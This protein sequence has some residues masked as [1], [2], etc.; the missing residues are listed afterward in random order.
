MAYA[1][2]VR[3][4]IIAAA[5]WMEA[6]Q[7]R[8]GEISTGLGS[9]DLDNTFMGCTW[10]PKDCYKPDPPMS[11]ASDVD[12]YNLAVIE[13]NAYLREVKSFEDCVIAEAKRDA[14]E[15]LP[16]LISQ[17]AKKA[18]DDADSEAREARESLDMM[19]PH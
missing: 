14:D 2:T 12:S 19:Q 9:C 13:F 4:A 10:K 5:L 18:L 3:S 16:D 8:A 17:S 1:L 7:A 11:Y 15:K 6:P